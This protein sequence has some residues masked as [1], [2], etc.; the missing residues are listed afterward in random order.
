MN[1]GIVI[2][3]IVVILLCGVMLVLGGCGQSIEQEAASL[4]AE[5]TAI[6]EAEDE[7]RK[8]AER[9]ITVERRKAVLDKAQALVD[10]KAV[11]ADKRDALRD[12]EDEE[13]A[14]Q[15]ADALDT[16]KSYF[17]GDG[18]QAMLNAVNHNIAPY[19]GSIA[20]VEALSELITYAFPIKDDGIYTEFIT[21]GRVLTDGG[22]LVRITITGDEF[23]VSAVIW[24][25]E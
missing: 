21:E 12:R 13:R 22:I 17:Q 4:D 14:R 18:A 5:A 7:L 25:G 10:R 3:G 15:A 24:R 23:N 1:G 19:G 11:L 6:A 8:E 16:V 9:A 20:S 2:P